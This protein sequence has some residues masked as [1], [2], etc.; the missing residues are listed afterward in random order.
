MAAVACGDSGDATGSGG[1][2]GGGDAPLTVETDH[3]PVTGSLVGSTRVFLGIP[4]AA[5][6]VGDLRW[7]PPVPAAAW[8]D[9]L[10][11]TTRGPE[12][13]QLDPL[14]G[15]YVAI[16]DEDCLTL[17]VWTP[18]KTAGSPLPV[19]VWIHGGGYVLGSG[20]EGTYDGQRLSEA[21]GAIVV[22]MNYRL[23]PLGFLSLPELDGEDAAH[24]ASGGYGLEDQR[25][26]LAW[27]K[28]NAAAFGGDPTRM[29]AFGESAGGASVCQHLVSK[30]SRGLFERAIIESG[31]CDLVATKTDAQAQGAALTTALGCDGADALAC[32]RGKTAEEVLGAL[33]LSADF[34]G[35][36]GATWRP[37]LDGWN[38]DDVP[39]T[40]LDA[41]D[42]E[43][44]P[45]ILG[46][47][48]DE[49]SLFF[50]LGATEIPDEPTLVSFADAFFPG[51]GQAIVDHYPSADYATP[52]DAAKAMS[53]DG[54]FV[55]PTRHMARALA[56]GGSAT[57]LYHFAFDPGSTLL[58]DLGVYHSSEIR[59]VFGNPSQL[60]PMPLA[61]A[62]LSMNADM[63]GYWARLG[64]AGDPN[65]EGAVPWPAYGDADE[66]LVLDQPVTT[67]S[68]H[69]K[70]ECDFWDGLLYP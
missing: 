13:P 49:A 51:Q 29:T 53:T 32:L 9:A 21:T 38:L 64:A 37:V 26:A 65:G 41:G 58:G 67:E 6:P 39:T 55:C 33:P 12:C 16:A 69:R 31:P 48:T 11:A 60:Q 56:K 14:S 25:A 34:S 1:G 52:T 43:V 35:G 3:G 24:P 46:T 22:T 40:L 61:D 19:L 57:F 18:S 8:S 47:N 5:P 63:Q 15:K 50:V 62:E 59:Y 66:D 54:G 30:K 27:V 7:K 36:D 10:L 68:G 4:F 28:A 70:A 17:D 23:G 45:T 20:G 44:M 2:G 42:F